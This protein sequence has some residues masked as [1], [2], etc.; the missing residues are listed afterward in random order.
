[1]RD[2]AP[3]KGKLKVIP[4]RPP[5]KELSMTSKIEKFAEYFRDPEE[6]HKIFT[7]LGFSFVDDSCGGW[8]PNCRER[9]S[10]QS[11]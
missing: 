1:M 8:C 2:R 10:L 3:F 11:L 7:E 9:D 5:T 4:L 6:N